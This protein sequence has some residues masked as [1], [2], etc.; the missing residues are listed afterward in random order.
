MIVKMNGCARC[1]VSHEIDFKELSAPSVIGGIT[2]THWAMCPTNQE[3]ILLR[4]IETPIEL[5]GALSE[6]RSFGVLP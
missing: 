4:I 6:A 5:A 1:G 2:L 3:P